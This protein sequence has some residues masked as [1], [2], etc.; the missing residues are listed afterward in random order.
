MPGGLISSGIL[1]FT[2]RRARLQAVMEWCA[3]ILQK[4]SQLLTLNHQL[5][6]H[7]RCDRHHWSYNARVGALKTK[8]RGRRAGLNRS[9]G[10]QSLS[11]RR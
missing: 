9:I 7:Q 2:S 5:F 10:R 4:I 3:P 1:L 8:P 11:G 6:P